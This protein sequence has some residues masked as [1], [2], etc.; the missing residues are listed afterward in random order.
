[1]LETLYILHLPLPLAITLLRPLHRRPI[2]GRHR[3]WKGRRVS[4]WELLPLNCIHAQTLVLV[5][6]RGVLQ[7][8]NQRRPSAL[9]LMIVSPTHSPRNMHIIASSRALSSNKVSTETIDT[10][11]VRTDKHGRPMMSARRSGT[12]SSRT[13]T[14]ANTAV[15]ASQSPTSPSPS[16]QS[17]SALLTGNIQH[18]DG[19]TEAGA[20]ARAMSSSVPR[21]GSTP[22][23][24]DLLEVNDG[25]RNKGDRPLPRPPGPPTSFTPPLRQAETNDRRHQ[26]DQIHAIRSAPSPSPKDPDQSSGQMTKSPYQRRVSSSTPSPSKSRLDPTA[27]R[28]EIDLPGN[29]G[30]DTPPE[31][32][33]PVTR[34]TR[35]PAHDQRSGKAHLLLESR[36]RSTNGSIL[37]RPFG[38]PSFDFLLAHPAIQSSLLGVIGINTF[39]SLSGS[40][41]NVRRQFTGESVGRW[42]L[43]E[44]TVRP[45]D[46]AG[47]RWPNLTVWEGFRTFR[48]TYPLDLA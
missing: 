18:A 40:S 16:P 4:R 3:D 19:L 22:L 2:I 34:S 35:F 26:A 33:P 12:S 10:P 43:N 1:M 41:E 7:V 25:Q 44:W 8:S 23:S 15:I 47:N 11:G 42:V 30:Y 24:P 48:P 29:P 5:P 38:R 13:I 32:L 14:R 31:I 9:E 37:Q 20:Y 21:S 28:K 46:Q 36:M 39:L 45:P 6:L 17:R 27:P